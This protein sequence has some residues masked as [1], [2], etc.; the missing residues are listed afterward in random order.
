VF[1]FILNRNNINSACNRVFDELSC[2]FSGS[3]NY[4]IQSEMNPV[5]DVQTSV[6][7]EEWNLHQGISDIVIKDVRISF[8]NLIPSVLA[9]KLEEL[10]KKLFLYFFL[11]DLENDLEENNT[12]DM[13]TGQDKLKP[14]IIQ[15]AVQIRSDIVSRVIS[16]HV[17]RRNLV[18]KLELLLCLEPHIQS[19][20]LIG[21]FA[22]AYFNDNENSNINGVN[23]G[24]HKVKLKFNFLFH[25]RI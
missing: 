9:M 14:K 8:S 10:R 25:K 3:P 5:Q 18:K 11:D 23:Q 1:N 6:Y 20:Y 21:D 7:T 16:F 15:I 12:A 13:I 19:Y 22:P 24:N 2:F 4:N 17:W